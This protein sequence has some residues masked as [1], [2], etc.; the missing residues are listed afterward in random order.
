MIDLDAMESYANTT[1]TFDNRI[2]HKETLL[3]LI[4]AARA[5]ESVNQCENKT[6]SI[7]EEVLHHALQPFRA[8]V[9]G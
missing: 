8:E 5:A 3:A 2:V 7:C 1:A 6:C 9:K 4:N